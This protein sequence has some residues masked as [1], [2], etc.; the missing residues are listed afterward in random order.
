[1]A[2]DATKVR[3]ALTGKIWLGK[4]A[5][6][7][8]PAN[9]SAAVDS[10]DFD[11][12][13]YTTDDGV[14][15][16]FGREVE[17][18]MGWQSADPLRKLVT[19]EPKSI[20]FV[21]RQLEKTTWLAAFGGTITGTSPNFSWAPPAPGSLEVRPLIVEF[22]DDTINYRFIY[23]RA[24]D[25][26]EKEMQLMRTDAVNIPANYSVL[27]GSPNSWFVQTNDPAMDPA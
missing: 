16:T 10:D 8:L 22:E 11:D 13:G 4:T 1:M 17:D 14:T 7:T 15:F 18:I 6:V 25:E 9:I 19:S 3:V 5:S 26:A 23:R 20:E 2:Q 21:L 24:S 12:L 27:A